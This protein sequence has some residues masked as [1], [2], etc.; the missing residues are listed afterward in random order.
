MFYD[1]RVHKIHISVET[2]MT[3][4]YAHALFFDLDNAVHNVDNLVNGIYAVQECVKPP[5]IQVRR[6]RTRAQYIACA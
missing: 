6:T 3:T 2:A 5:A 4:D 1:V